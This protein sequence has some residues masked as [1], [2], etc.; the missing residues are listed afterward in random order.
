MKNE[1][2]YY[3]YQK[4]EAEKERPGFFKWVDCTKKE[5]FE[6]L[7]IDKYCVTKKRK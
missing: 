3:Q 5:Y 4:A 1:S 6:L 7:K 2:D